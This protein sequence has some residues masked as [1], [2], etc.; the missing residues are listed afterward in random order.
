MTDV[1]KRDG[2]RE[3]LDISKIHGHVAWAC[4]DLEGVSQS[5]VEANAKIMFFDGIKSSDIQKALVKSAASLI[6]E[7]A[8][9]YTFVASKLL[10][11]TVYKEITGGDFNYPHLANYVRRGVEEKRLDPNLF[12]GFDLDKL[13]AA[14]RPERDYQFTYLGLQTV[15]DRYL[16]RAQVQVGQDKGALI[17]MPQ[18][19]LMRVA[20]G[21]ALNEKPE[22]RNERAIEFYDVLSTFDFM[23]STPTLFNA[24]TLHPQMS[25]CYLNTMDD[26]IGDM[27]G[28]VGIFNTVVENANLSKFAGGIGTDFSPVRP[29]GSPIQ[30]TN[31]ISSGV[32]PYMKVMNDTAVAVNQ[33]GKRNGAIAMYLEPTHADFMDFC[34][35]KKQAGDE[36]RRTHDA[37]PVS[38]TPDLFMKRV[39]EAE[40][41]RKSGGDPS[42][43]KWSFFAHPYHAELHE[44]YGEKFEER[45]LQLE[46]EGKFHKQV[47]I[48]EVWRKWITNLV[49]TGHP[50]ITF[51]DEA[52]RRNPQDHVGIIHSSN[53]C[54][55]IT[56]NTS[57]DETAVCN[58]GSIN[59]SRHIDDENG[60]DHDKLRKTI[61][62][63]MRMLDNVID[64]NFYPS[65]K[66]RNANMRHR[67]VG[68]GVMGLTEMLVANGIDWESEENI[69]F[70]DELFEVI[71]YYAIEA[72]SDLAAERGTY[73]SYYGSKW[74]RGIFPI[75]T[76]K[77]KGQ[78]HQDEWDKLREKVRKQ[79]M[80]NSN[81]MA[82]AP[83]A[84]I[85]NITGTTPCIEPIYQKSY[86]KENK[87]GIFD[88]VDPCFKYGRPELIKEAFE[89]DQTW[90]IRAGAVRQK[91]IDQAQSL[92]LFRKLGMKGSEVSALYILAWELGLKTTY[93]L[94]NQQKKSTGGEVI[95]DVNGGSAAIACSID[96]PEACESCQ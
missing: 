29:M 32:V 23:S 21:L 19:F 33:G 30:S 68:L 78:R 2:S 54:T 71:S 61:R 58:L 51:K 74:H 67:P 45:Y 24:G 85:A 6:S 28:Q 49:Q 40:S 12:G 87:S 52:N 10:L 75:D 16:I 50:W 77:L 57:S 15:A 37:F 36:R 86:Q 81:T 53:L 90:I 5:E 79:G 94:R 64:L 95:Q 35:L 20:M 66:A 82:I 39:V 89:I 41:I 83:T 76:A 34:D 9:N 62:T 91:W 22:Q 3:P 93:Y 47:P 42:G 56:L 25:S 63:A 11:M 55:E 1:I 43:V 92:N 70:Q 44:L 7:E 80:R 59:L 38:W 26:S 27:G 18:H 96:N 4:R 46:A 72:S 31:G 69:A 73:Q 48:M 84:T 14:I 17:E 65:P 60:F 88:V 13:N 8:P